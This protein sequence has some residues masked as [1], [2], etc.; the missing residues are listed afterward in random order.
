MPPIIV[1]QPWSDDVAEDLRQPNGQLVI[2]PTTGQP[3]R[4]YHAQIIIWAALTAHPRKP[5]TA[6]TPLFPVLLDTGFNET[7]LMQQRQ[8]EAWLTPAVFAAFKIRGRAFQA[9]RE[10]IPGWDMALW[11]Y[12]NV[13]DTRDPDTA[14][15]P[16][17]LA[18]PLGVPLTPPG[19]AHTKEKPLLGLR[20]IRVNDLSLRID[21]RRRRVWLDAP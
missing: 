4:A 19:S 17:P 9:G 7:F 15:T 1:G 18:L 20:A 12:P 3:L 8:A 10:S 21:G 6:G 11:L 13:P 2:C 5:P 16:V 14:S